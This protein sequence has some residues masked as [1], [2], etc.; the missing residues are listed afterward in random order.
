MAT[1]S[2]SLGYES[3]CTHDI[4]AA[5]AVRSASWLNDKPNVRSALRIPMVN[6]GRTNFLGF[7]LAED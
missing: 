4:S 2:D 1:Q 6:S 7:R 5:R 3:F